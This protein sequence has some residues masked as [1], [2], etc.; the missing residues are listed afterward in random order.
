[1]RR[2]GTN[3]AVIVSLLLVAVVGAVSIPAWGGE[4]YPEVNFFRH[5]KAPER[6][7][8][9]YEQYPDDVEQA[10]AAWSKTRPLLERQLTFAKVKQELGLDASDLGFAEGVGTP[11]GIIGFPLNPFAHIDKG[12]GRRW[13]IFDGVYGPLR[14]APPL[15]VRWIKT[16]VTYDTIDRSIIRVTMTIDGEKF[17]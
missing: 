1:M 8:L 4:A 6:E 14:S 17:E 12:S 13:L 11:A 3:R 10:Q 16:Y 5:G 7:W 2:D 15:V 9:P